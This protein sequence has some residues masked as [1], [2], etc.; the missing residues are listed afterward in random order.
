MVFLGA[1]DE[2]YISNDEVES[3]HQIRIVSL[4]KSA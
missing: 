3:V 1:R 2:I 4:V